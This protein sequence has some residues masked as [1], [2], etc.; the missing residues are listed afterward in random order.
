LVGWLVGWLVDWLID[1]C[2]LFHSLS[3]KCW[4]SLKLP[5]VSA[6]AQEKKEK[7]GGA[8]SKSVLDRNR[9]TDTAQSPAL[10]LVLRLCCGSRSH[11]GGQAGYDARH[12]TMAR[13]I[14]CDDDDEDEEESED[15]TG[16]RTDLL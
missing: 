7:Y 2:Y 10:A 6:N 9:P 5:S 8:A 12:S 3:A 1:C 14:A 16:Q 11:R 4:Q 13:L 15:N